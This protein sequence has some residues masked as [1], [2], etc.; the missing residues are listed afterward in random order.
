MLNTVRCRYNAVYFLQNPHNRHPIARPWGRAMRY[1]LWI[2]TVTYVL[3]QSLLYCIQY[4]V[5]LERVVTAL[6]VYTHN[7]VFFLLRV[8]TIDYGFITCCIYFL[9]GCI[10]GAGS[11]I[12]SSQW[13]HNGCDSVSNHQPHDC[14]LNR[15]FR[16]RS[17]KTSK[18]RVTG[19][20]MRNSPGTGE[21]PAQMA[22][23]AKM[24]PF[25]DVIMK[26]P[27]TREITRDG[28]AKLSCTKP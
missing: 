8:S 10:A 4:H 5:M 23:N 2:Q 18:L 27:C 15:L 11:I 17:K 25:D 16:R 12:K 22:C 6:T 24:F 14:L 26:F 13:R 19:L 28:L 1:L 21:F 3:S 7:F 9:T 20:G